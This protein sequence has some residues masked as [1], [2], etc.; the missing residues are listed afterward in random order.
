MFEFCVHPPDH[1]V[2]VL[3]HVLVVAG[4]VVPVLK[5]GPCAGAERFVRWR[6][7]IVELRAI[8]SR[9]E[10]PVRE[11]HREVNE[12]RIVPVPLHEIDDVVGENVLAVFALHVFEKFPVFVDDRALVAGTLFFGVVGVP[13]AEFVEPGVLDFLT[14][15]ARL[16]H[17]VGR[18]IGMELPF[19]CDAGL[20]AGAGEQVAKGNFVG[21]DQAEADVV[22]EVVLAGHQLDAGRRAQG[23]DV[24]VFKADSGACHAIEHRGCVRGPSVCPDRFVSEVVGHD[25]NDIGAA[26]AGRAHRGILCVGLADPG[27]KIP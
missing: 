2:V 6:N 7:E 26:V 5:L 16:W 10:G 8:G 21:C 17:F 3:D 15:R 23:L 12:E 24:G 9:L 22:A 25:Q 20:V 27:R 19:A 14:R 13:H 11:G 18:V 4:L 1:L